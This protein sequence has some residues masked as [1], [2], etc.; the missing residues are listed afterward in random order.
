MPFFIGSA[1]S[2]P[3]W[4]AL[5]DCGV[6]VAFLDISD[7]IRAMRVR[8]S[9]GTTVVD[10]PGLGIDDLPGSVAWYHPG[11]FEML[12]EQFVVQDS[13]LRF[14]SRQFSA[15]LEFIE[16]WLE[17]N[18]LCIDS[19]SRQ[20]KYSN[21]ITQLA[22]LWES[23]SELLPAT[24]VSSAPDPS[25]LGMVI[26]RLSENRYVARSTAFY[27]RV[28]DLDALR[29]LKLGHPC[30][31]VYQERIDSNIEYRTFCMDQY[32]VTVKMPRGQGSPVVDMHF[33]PNTFADA[34]LASD[35][36]ISDVLSSLQH[37]LG[38]RFMAVD[39]A[40]LNTRVKVFEVN[41]LFSFEW[42]PKAG[43]AALAMAVSQAFLAE[44]IN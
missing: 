30:P 4:E 1:I 33:H 19:P 44:D 29:L 32:R 27:S 37:A 8:L 12:S 3:S 5:Q 40:V 15:A 18:C 21:R 17:R 24:I 23:D 36:A 2:K 6:E 43:L 28:V 16:L 35:P 41:P 38:L 11:Q 34:Q 22:R 14:V 42:L 31:M 20:R 7:L 13:E 9:R 26:K 39:Y 25:F 10:F